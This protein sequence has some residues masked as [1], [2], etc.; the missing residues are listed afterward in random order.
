S[1]DSLREVQR[2]LAADGLDGWLLYDFNGANPIAAGVL[3]LPP[4]TRRLFVF[5]PVRGRPVA[6][7]HTIEQQP[8]QGW[9]GE[10]RTYLGWESFQE[11]LVGLLAG[12]GTIACEYSPDDSVPYLDRVPAG[13]FELINRAGVRI[14]S[15]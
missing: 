8:W 13:L 3:G 12:S 6:L 4:L 9:I 10:N 7:T 11:G 15:S 5:L 1:E 2:R 14:V